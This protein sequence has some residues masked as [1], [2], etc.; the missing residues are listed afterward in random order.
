LGLKRHL[1]FGNPGARQVISGPLDEGVPSLLL[2]PLPFG[3]RALQGP[4]GRLTQDVP[5]LLKLGRQPGLHMQQ[6]D[7]NPRLWPLPVRTP[8]LSSS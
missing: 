6:R 8:G 1:G 4:G 5:V 3:N 7:L 2:S